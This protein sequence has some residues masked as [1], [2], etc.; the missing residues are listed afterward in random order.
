M[1]KTKNTQTVLITG[2]T[3]NVGKNLIRRLAV[4]GYELIGTTS[5]DSSK[6]ISGIDLREVNLLDERQV[7][8][9]ANEITIQYGG[10][11]AIVLLVGG[12]RD[13]PF[14]K[15]TTDDIRSMV[16]INFFTA[17]HVLQSFLPGMRARGF[18]RIILTGA[19]IAERTNEARHAFAYAVSKRMVLDMAELIQESYGRDGI[20]VSVLLPGTIHEANTND[21]GVSPMEV[22]EAIEL[23]LSQKTK[24]WKMPVIRM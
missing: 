4:S 1:S 24:K 17:F 8:K 15:T 19:A 10:V 3:G 16:D 5:R 11:D 6:I 21:D 14:E 20:H 22:S 2:A 23:L 7:D 9:L 12:F 18:G 13:G